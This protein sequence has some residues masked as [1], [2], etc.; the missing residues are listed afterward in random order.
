MTQYVII[1][2]GDNMSL[3]ERYEI[4]LNQLLNGAKEFYEGETA[5][6]MEIVIDALQ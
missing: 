1:N 2:K 4:R 5:I 3:M 6:I